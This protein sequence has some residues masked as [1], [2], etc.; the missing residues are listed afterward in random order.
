MAELQQ[1]GSRSGLLTTVYFNLF[2]NFPE[3]RFERGWI[4]TTSP[5]N[6]GEPGDGLRASQGLACEEWRLLEWSGLSPIPSN[7]S[8][9]LGSRGKRF[10][11]MPP[12]PTIILSD[13]ICNQQ[14]IF[15]NLCV[16]M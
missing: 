1:S 15:E 4:N 12:D 7:S 10:I 3:L 8:F 9:I 5:Q 2:F 16:L 13:L 11:L 6:T 14:E